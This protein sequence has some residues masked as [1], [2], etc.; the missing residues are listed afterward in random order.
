MQAYLA[1]SIG[2][3]FFASLKI[4]FKLKRA[5]GALRCNMT[6]GLEHS[7]QK[8]P[9]V[10]LKLQVIPNLVVLSSKFEEGP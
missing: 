6:R 7:S 1:Y 3:S 5:K 9:Q 2:H 4:F 8:T 10:S